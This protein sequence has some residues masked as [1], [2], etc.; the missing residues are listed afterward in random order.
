M[1]VVLSAAVFVMPPAVAEVQRVSPITSV[2]PM[3]LPDPVRWQ[4]HQ[5]CWSAALREQTDL[6]TELL[7]FVSDRR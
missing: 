6:T 5:R 7:R 4:D 2:A 3:A 1:P